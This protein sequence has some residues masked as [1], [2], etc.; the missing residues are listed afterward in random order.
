MKKTKSIT[1]IFLILF[2]LSACSSRP[3]YMDETTYKLGTKALE[4]MD[5][6]NNAE[7]TEDEARKQLDEIYSR[8]S[9]RTFSDDES[10]QE[11]Q[12]ESVKASV[13]GYEI[14]MSSKGNIYEEADSLREKLNK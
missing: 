5:Q 11:V 13:L 2:L 3:K 6:Y 8:L 12:N 14:T 1:A 9:V 4:I 7:L 10:S